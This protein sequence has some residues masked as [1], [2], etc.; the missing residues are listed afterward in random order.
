MWTPGKGRRE[1]KFDV[2]NHVA[3]YERFENRT[4]HPNMAKF[5]HTVL[6]KALRP[7]SHFS[8]GAKEQMKWALDHG[9]LIALALTHGKLLDP[10]QIA[11][12]VQRE[13]ALRKMR[14]TSMIGAKVSLYT[15]LPLLGPIITDIGARPVWREKDVL[16]K[17]MNLEGAMTALEHQEAA[18]KEFIRSAIRSMN[19]GTNL[20]MHVEG[21]RNQEPDFTLAEDGLPR[22]LPVKKG[23]GY[24]VSAV[25]PD[26][27]ILIATAAFSYSPD[28]SW[29]DAAIHFDVPEVQD[30]RDPDEVTDVITQSMRYGLKQ[31]RSYNLGEQLVAA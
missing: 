20:A 10:P 8:E 30:R 31:A 18:G 13:K 27:N 16:N 6:G 2:A 3:I 14:G 7:D 15:G 24:I 1:T 12:A 23:F 5:Y 4:P 19:N 9:H 28:A 29:R 25:N 21:T 22:M 11:A 17:D 26:I